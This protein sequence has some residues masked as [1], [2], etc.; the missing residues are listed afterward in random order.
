MAGA[1]NLDPAGAAEA[2]NAIQRFLVA[3]TRL[4]IPAIL[5]EEALHGLLA[6][7]AVSFQQSIGAGAAF[8][9]ELVEAIAA[10]IRRRMLAIGGRLALAP[11]LDVT[12]DPRWGRVEETYG[13]D[14]YLATVLG[15]AYTRGMQGDDISDGVVATGKHLVGHGLA[16]GGL[17]QAPAHVGP[18]ELRDEQL[19]PF[20]AAV[21]LAG[22]ACMM[23]AYCD[24]D[25]LPCHASSELL[26]T[27]LRDEWGFDGIVASDYTA[28]QMLVGQHRLTGDLGTAA[29]MALRAGLDSELPATAGYGAPLQAAVDDGRVD[30]ALVDLAVERILRLKF[31]LGLFERPYVD[32]PSVAELDQMDAEERSLA[33]DLVRRSIVLLQNDGV[34]PLAGD[35]GRIAVIGPIADSARDLMGDYAHMPHIET[36]AELRHRA[37]PFGFP[38]SDVIQPTDEV[39]SWPTILDAL[40]DRFGASRITHARGTGLRDGT[41]EAIAE[42]VAL[43]RDAEVAIVVL[44]ERSGL[45]DDATTGEARDRRDLGLLGRQ[46]ELLEAVVATGTPTVLVVVSGR[47]LALEWAAAHCAA[48]LVAWVP[49]RGRARGDRGGPRGRRRPG[50]PAADHAAAP[51]GP[52]PADLPPPPHRRPVELEGGLRRRVRG[53]AVPVRVRALV[54]DVLD[55]PAA[56]RAPRRSTRPA[57]RRSSGSTSPTRAPVPAR[58]SSSSTCATRRRRSPGRSSSCAG[59]GASGSSPAS[60]ARSRSA[61]RPSSW[62]TSAPT[63]G[64]S[65]SRASC[66]C[67]SAG[68]RPTCRCRR[69]SRSTGPAIELVE[70]SRYVTEV[71]D[72]AEA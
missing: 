25:G 66:G 4:G 51:R 71:S 63:T 68:R 36:L 58:T 37:N 12:R 39:G 28:V 1:T 3:E 43:A 41:D 10:T 14:P 62:P 48:I 42:A 50:W 8:D 32:P 65:S 24:V 34:L 61:C 49:G 29:G 6:R 15:V 9:P 70:R 31:R 56:G 64:G 30:P 59:S 23:P 44:G 13:E 33:A 19:L 69:R 17:N 26:T 55:R 38:S 67:S 52:G 53:A 2:G 5:H 57:T 35:G 20:E 72:A 11:V 7:D 22:M 16:E 46:Q 45:T 40:R 47:P 21:R 60:A 18:R 27:I 54:H